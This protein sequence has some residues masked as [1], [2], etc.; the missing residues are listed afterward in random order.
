MDIIN[1]LKKNILDNSTNSIKYYFTKSKI[2]LYVL[3]ILEYRFVSFKISS[4]I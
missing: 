4:S 2:H 3:I 1:Q